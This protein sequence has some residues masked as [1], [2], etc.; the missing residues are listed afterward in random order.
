M[1]PRKISG[2]MESIPGRLDLPFRLSIAPYIFTKVTKVPATYL[3]EESWDNICHIIHENKLYKYF[4]TYLN[5][6]KV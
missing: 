5:Y 6:N 4:S 2:Q 3:H 1:L